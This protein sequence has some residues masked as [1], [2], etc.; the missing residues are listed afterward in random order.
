M[1]RPVLYAVRASR[2]VI[3][4]RNCVF[5][6]LRHD[7]Q[8]LPKR[9]TLSDSQELAEFQKELGQQVS[10]LIGFQPHQHLLNERSFGEVRREGISNREAAFMK[11][12]QGILVPALLCSKPTQAPKPVV[13][14]GM[15]E[16][17]RR[18]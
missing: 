9:K 17:R 2:N 4:W 18:M 13:L 7:Q 14:Y 10:Q 11:A 5:L 3:G 6:E 16:T 15:D 8:I 1:K 12:S